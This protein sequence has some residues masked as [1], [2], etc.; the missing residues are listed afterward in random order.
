MAKDVTYGL[1]LATYGL[2]QKTARRRWIIAFKM[3]LVLQS[4]AF[5]SVFWMS[6]KK[7]AY[8]A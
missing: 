5:L 3:K 7:W 2:I 6:F 4:P 1:F 8:E